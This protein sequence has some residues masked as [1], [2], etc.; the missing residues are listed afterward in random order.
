MLKV[1][2]EFSSQPISLIKVALYKMEIY[3]KHYMILRI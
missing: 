1:T 3:L 2:N